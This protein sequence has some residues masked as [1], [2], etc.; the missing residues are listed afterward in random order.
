M[1]NPFFSII[2]PTY[3]SINTLSACLD[4]IVN[5]SLQNFEILIMDGLSKDGTI[6]IVKK[7]EA[8]NANIRWV[9]EKDKGIY[10]AM[11]KGVKMAK[12]EWIYFLGS[13]DLINNNQILQKIFSLNKS[14]Y[15]VVYGNAKIVGDTSW[16][17][18]GELYDGK[19][20]LQKLL[21]KNICHQA[22]FYNKNCFANGSSLFN[23]DYKLC[24]DYDFNLRC[25]ANH[26][27]LYIN[28]TIVD[29]YGGGKSTQHNS[30]ELF[31]KDFN[32]NRLTYFGNNVQADA[33]RNK[34]INFSNVSKNRYKKAIRKLFSFFSSDHLKFF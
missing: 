15:E 19:F 27:F 31:I 14:G 25:W 23:N 18:D 30:D 3:N 7:Y 34:V 1:R 21:K 5:Q 24:A 2:I 8:G 26:P 22:I 6:P 13:D 17:K 20:D 29:F 11:N 16:A 32:K 33:H 10:D 28:L 4:S 12:G 9:S